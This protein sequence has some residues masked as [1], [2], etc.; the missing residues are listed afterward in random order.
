MDG[1]DYVG[2]DGPFRDVLKY[3]FGGGRFVAFAGREIP[4]ELADGSVV[5]LKNHWWHSHIKGFA[6][7]AY[8]DV[9]S[10]T[11]CYVFYGGV[12][13][14][15]DDLATLRATY[16][17]PIIPYWDYEKLIRNTAAL[18]NAGAAK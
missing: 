14:S 9:E 4:I 12:C 6:S 15:P 18:A 17:G 3:Q 11:R 5:T 7:C 2:S 1:R 8:G 10:L 16:A 13:I